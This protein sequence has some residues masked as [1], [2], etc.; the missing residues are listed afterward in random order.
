M[1][2]HTKEKAWIPKL[3]EETTSNTKREL[4]S[5]HKT[6][7]QSCDRSEL[8][9]VKRRRHNCIFQINRPGER[10]GRRDEEEEKVQQTPMDVQQKAE[11]I[12]KAPVD[13][14]QSA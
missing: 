4:K 5:N 14:D 3:G 12:L 11:N 9:D 7:I 1:L 10:A 2:N 8:A 13:T 6:Q